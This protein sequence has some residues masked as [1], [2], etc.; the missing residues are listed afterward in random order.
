MLSLAISPSKDH[1]IT[2]SADATI[3]KHPL[4]SAKS[5]WKT[6]M[7]PV[8]VSSTKHSGQ[9]GLSY[10]SDGRIYAT[11]GWDAHIRVYSGR[12]MKELAV[13]KW[14]KPGCYATAFASVSPADKSTPIKEVDG[15]F[16]VS[17]EMNKAGSA[18]STVQQRRD[19]K[20][21]TTHW[22]A[23]GAKDGK[24]SLWDIY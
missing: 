5:I 21:Q 13:L 20:A 11:A 10:R 2:S 14:H 18:I 4:P 16:E 12:T 1:Y 8:K 6:E 9:Q 22:L 24:V 17:T 23:A 7:K 3:A 15:S 19:E